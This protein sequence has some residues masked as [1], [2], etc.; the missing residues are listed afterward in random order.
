MI[1][2]DKIM[3]ERKKNGWSQEELAAQ[4]GVSR[5]MV[6]N[7]EGA[8]AIP[9]LQT[10]IKLSQIFDVS[11]D[12]LLKDEMENEIEP[13]ELGEEVMNEKDLIRV[14]MKEA[15]E[16]IECSRAV[17]PKHAL[18][19][20]LCILSPVTLLF[21]SGVIES[22]K[23]VLDESLAYGVGLITL[24][25]MISMAAA[26]FIISNAKMKKYEYLKQGNFETEY[27]IIGY[28]KELKEEEQQKST[29]KTVIGTILCICCALPLISASLT[30]AADVILIWMVC[31]LLCMIAAAVYLFTTAHAVN[32]CCDVLLK[33][34]EYTE[35]NQKN[36]K[37]M[38]IISSVFWS[39]IVAIYIA[40]SFYTMDWG[41][42]WII[43]PIA[44]VVHSVISTIVKA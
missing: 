24:F 6:S 16:Y 22:G 40:W 15:N 10:L 44:G 38:S 37:T 18:G 14:S 21:L 7:W 36:N 13:E 4:L 8:Q 30:D 1:L 23:K 25:L 33:E 19:T 32:S 28:A 27:G 31:V 29:M 41:R 3:N 20:V 26:L 34:G 43:W 39:I 2:A 42:T 5:Q 9:D 35:Q 17:A 11:T 12:Y